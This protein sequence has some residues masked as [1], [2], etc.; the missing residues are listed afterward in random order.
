MIII[1]VYSELENV[2]RR[3]RGYID[4]CILLGNELV[5][6]YNIT[7]VAYQTNKNGRS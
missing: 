5:T 3:P 1:A 2:Q 7:Y 6:L 4:G